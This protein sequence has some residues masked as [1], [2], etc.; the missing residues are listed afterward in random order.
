MRLSLKEAAKKLRKYL[1]SLPIQKFFGKIEL[2]LENGKVV[3]TKI[4]ETLE[5][6]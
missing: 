4:Y 1:S 2:T 5:K 3:N 6:E